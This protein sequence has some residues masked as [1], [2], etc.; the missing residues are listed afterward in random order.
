MK[1]KV[2]FATG[3]EGKMP[4]VSETDGC[5]CEKGAHRKRPENR[6]RTG[7]GG[8]HRSVLIYKH[9]LIQ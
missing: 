5:C 7:W 6:L 1:E 4:G 8:T 2:I 3:N 9:A